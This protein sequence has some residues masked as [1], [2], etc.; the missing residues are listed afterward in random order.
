MVDARAQ[1]I[2]AMERDRADRGLADATARAA[3]AVRG[4]VSDGPVKLVND[5]VIRL[6]REAERAEAR[7]EN[8]ERISE[9]LDQQCATHR[10]K[11]EQSTEAIRAA[12]TRAAQ[13]RAEVVAELVPQAVEDGESYLTAVA[14]E[15]T[16]SDR[17]AANASRYSR[18][19]WEPNACAATRYEPGSSAPNEKSTMRVFGRRKLVARWK[20][21]A[22]CRPRKPPY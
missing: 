18:K 4:L 13:A 15:C 12:E 3:E 11:D 7:A 2:E 5:E 16:A 9:R 6:V 21:C 17:L 19:S 8:W 1:F 14:T 20:S 10:A 22:L